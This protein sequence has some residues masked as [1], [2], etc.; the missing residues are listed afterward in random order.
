M[1]KFAHLCLLTKL[2]MLVSDPRHV[3]KRAKVFFRRTGCRAERY[4]VWVHPSRTRPA[5]PVGNGALDRRTFANHIRP[6]LVS[7]TLGVS[8]RKPFH[9]L[10]ALL[11]VISMRRQ[12]H[13]RRRLM[14][15]IQ[16]TGHL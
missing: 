12:H 1:A 2:L 14:P 16:L 10:A 5:R 8:I 9:P 7:V 6:A 4:E 3:L 15:P 11:A 13:W